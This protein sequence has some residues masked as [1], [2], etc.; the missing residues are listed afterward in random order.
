MKFSVEATCGRARAGR[1][2]TAR[3]A[4]ETPI[5]M[6][7]GT[8]GTVKAMTPRELE[9]LGAQIIL[10]NTYHLYLRPGLEVVRSA[11]GLHELMGWSRP[12]LTDSGGYQVFSLR[13][14]CE[15]SDEGV[16][17]QSHI[18]GSRHELT[19]EKSIEIQATLGAD[20]AMAFDHCPAAD[21]PAEKVE[22]AMAR[23]TRWAQQSLDAAR[24]RE[25]TIFGIVQ[26]AADLA[27]RRRHMAEICAL[28]FDGFA[29][30]G[31]SVG[32]PIPVMYALLDA[33]A[34][35]LPRDRPRYLMGVGT[36]ADLLTAIEAGI[37]MFDCVMP[38]R[39][40]RNGSLFTRGGRINIAN[41]EHR[42]AHAPIDDGCVCETCETFTR[43]YLRH[44]YL[45]KE[46]LYMRLATL[47]NLHHYLELVRGARSAI[48][49]GCYPAY[50]KTILDGAGVG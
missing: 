34:D 40:A 43:A 45:A 30:G 6:P 1:I 31:F 47:H 9:S 25:Q 37:D 4:I 44:L 32:E 42:L 29:L 38:T 39:H 48:A 17:F 8:A 2:E 46:I 33:I 24:A 18:D 13:D 21:A 10:G 7:V 19:P 41:A 11:G 22:E 23:T 15:I 27:L 14:L 12:I 36:P 28:P 5:F 3:G 35:E 49:S 16:I 20:I 50:R 26:G